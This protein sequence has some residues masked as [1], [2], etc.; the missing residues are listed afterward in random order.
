MDAPYF[1][2]TKSMTADEIDQLVDIIT[3][4]DPTST[5]TGILQ[6]RE[7]KPI[8]VKQE[9][10]NQTPASKRRV[11]TDIDADFATRAAKRRDC[12]RAMK[13]RFNQLVEENRRLKEEKE[14][15][16]KEKTSFEDALGVVNEENEILKQVIEGR[17]FLK[18]V[19]PSAGSPVGAKFS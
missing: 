12:E 13:E 8:V 18:P 14:A 11:G 19:S 17:L 7:V 9:Q 5:Q 2:L 4:F 16:L 10:T 15:W 6:G 3:D 1:D